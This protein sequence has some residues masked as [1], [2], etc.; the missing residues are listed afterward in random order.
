MLMLDTVL[1]VFIIAH[2]F[3]VSWVMFKVSAELYM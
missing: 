2:K 3:M 1:K